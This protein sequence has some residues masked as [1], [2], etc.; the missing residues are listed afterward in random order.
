MDRNDTLLKSL[1]TE[2]L[3]EALKGLGGITAP[4]AKAG[5]QP[6]VQQA[7]QPGQVQQSNPVEKDVKKTTKYPKIAGRLHEVRGAT[8]ISVKF[9]NIYI[10]DAEN[11][12]KMG[13]GRR[14]GFS[15]IFNRSLVGS[16]GE[17]PMA[18]LKKWALAKD[19]NGNE[20]PIFRFLSILANSTTCDYYV[21]IRGT[22][23]VGDGK[24]GAV[25]LRPDNRDLA[26]RYFISSLVGEI[27]DKSAVEVLSTKN[28][29]FDKIV[30]R[31]REAFMDGTFRDALKNYGRNF[32]WIDKQ[33]GI[34]LS[35]RN[36][37]QIIATAIAYGLTPQSPNWPTFVRSRE[38]WR[39]LGFY[40]C[41]DPNLPNPREPLQY[42]YDVAIPNQKKSNRLINQGLKQM[43]HDSLTYKDVSSAN[44][45]LT[46]LADAAY[47]FAAGFSKGYHGVGY[48]ISDV[49][50]IP[51]SNV[52]S[53][54]KQKMGLKNNLTG[55]LNQS[56]VDYNDQKKTEFDQN[57]A[58]FKKDAE[59]DP[60]LIAA[61]KK[62]ESDKKTAEMLNKALEII[63]KN[64]SGE[65]S[66][67]K[68]FKIVK[69]MDEVDN[70]IMTVRNWAKSVVDTYHLAK[71]AKETSDLVTCAICLQAGIGEERVSGV[72]GDLGRAYGLL[73]S[74][75][76][77]KA[78]FVGYIISAEEAMAS[79][80]DEVL[81]WL[82]RNERKNSEEEEPAEAGSVVNEEAEMLN[83]YRFLKNISGSELVAKLIS[84]A[85]E[86][87]FDDNE[88]LN[89]SSLTKSYKNMLKRMNSLG[90]YG[91]G[92]R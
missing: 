73:A 14:E 58:K 75:D 19:S 59:N 12:Q 32:R 29:D 64:L 39:R 2:V 84:I 8:Y 51:G 85:R 86:K 66:P 23:V 89:E 62:A 54:F 33:Y 28:I 18:A 68:P 6:K 91:Y 13:L 80:L 42:P 45:E 3:D 11:A 57:M 48:D 40:V 27:R 76:S 17:D 47:R 25:V 77:D 52:A 69:T 55:E 38:T 41:D 10:A 90:E 78:D 34:K 63:S 61:A 21:D 79:E 1:I 65:N 7:Q 71:T 5:Q 9:D 30:E 24:D 74:N 49:V 83:E 31:L 87:G 82:E 22:G 67:I 37:R 53:E 88:M 35:P 72:I 16:N 36:V 20:P 26:A 50:E 43:G 44:A 81:V 70:F 92:S 4:I 15:F 46:Q 56:A 60:S